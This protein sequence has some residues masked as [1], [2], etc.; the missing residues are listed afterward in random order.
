[1]LGFALSL[2]YMLLKSVKISWFTKGITIYEIFFVIITITR[3]GNIFQSFV[4]AC[5]IIGEMLLFE[6]A[7]DGGKEQLIHFLDLVCGI[8]S[9]YVFINL[10]TVIAFPNGI[11]LNEMNTPI[12]FLGIHNRFVFWM[13]PLMCFLCISSYIKNKRIGLIF[14]TLYMISL[15]TLLSKLALGA[16]IGMIIFLAFLILGQIQDFW[17]M[18][19]KILIFIYIIIWVLLTLTNAIDIINLGFVVMYNKSGN[20]LA[21]LTLWDTAKKFLITDLNHLI[22]GYGLESDKIIWQKFRF[23]HVHNN[24]LNVFYQT[25]VVGGIMYFLPFVK[26]MNPLNRFKVTNE[27]KVLTFTIIAFLAML[28]VD[29]YDLYGHFYLLG[30]LASNLDRIKGSPKD[31]L[32]TSEF[33]D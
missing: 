2:T 26:L 23:A 16:S 24:L 14:Y 6:I 30:V 21:R 8:M 1:M 13:L 28:L 9:A 5:T 15:V 31:K 7:I 22:F 20:I 25:G 11:G 12:Y 17:W 19:Y 33:I 32:L 3:G 4:S 29:T 18:D 27:A 10:Y